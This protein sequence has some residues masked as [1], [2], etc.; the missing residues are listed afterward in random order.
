[1]CNYHITNG[2]CIKYTLSKRRISDYIFTIDRVSANFPRATDLFAGYTVY[3]NMYCYGCNMRIFVDN[4][5]KKYS[6]Y[7]FYILNY[8]Y[9]FIS[10]K[11]SIKNKHYINNFNF[12]KNLKNIKEIM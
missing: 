5:T 10:I 3:S 9:I 1:M 12:I 11:K 4:I 2:I 8:I 7:I 6:L